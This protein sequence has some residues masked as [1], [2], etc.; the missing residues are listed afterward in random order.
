M[1]VKHAK[2]TLIIAEVIK[3]NQVVNITKNYKKLY[4]RKKIFSGSLKNLI[5]I[6]NYSKYFYN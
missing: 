6:T 1:R 3:E 5:C 2:I 4:K